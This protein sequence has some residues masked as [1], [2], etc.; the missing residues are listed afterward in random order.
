MSYPIWTPAEVS[1][2]ARFERREAWRVVEA[3]HVVSTMKLVD[4]LSEQAL[5]EE[6]VEERKPPMPAD[7]EGLH[8][9]LFTP[10]RYSPL[11]GGSRFRGDADPGVWYGAERM[12]TAAAEMSY[13]RLRFMRDAGFERLPPTPYSAF[14]VQ[15]A[16]E[17]VDLRRPPFDRDAKFWMHPG[18]YSATQAFARVAREAPLAAVIWQS[19][20]DPEPH[21]CIAILMPIAFQSKTPENLQ[22]WTLTML[23]KEAAWHSQGESAFSFVTKAWG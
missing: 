23:P 14:S 18:D 13:W 12:A 15:V 9:L 22:T 4:S 6:V 5:L 8:Y 2:E 19:V 17:M 16:G 1:S 7:A 3:Q 10:F 11:P 21:C 20:R